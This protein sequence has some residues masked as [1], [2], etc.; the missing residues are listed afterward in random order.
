MAAR[1]LQMLI[2]GVGCGP[3]LRFLVEVPLLSPIHVGVLGA[4]GAVGAHLVRLLAGHPWFELTE[5]GASGD[6][7][8]ASLARRLRELGGGDVSEAAGDLE[9]RDL[10]DEWEAPLLLSALPSDVAG[11]LEAKLAVRGHLVVSNASAHRMGKDIPLVV[12]EVNPDHLALLD[13]LGEGAGGVVTNPNCVAA[14]LAVVL[15]PLHQALGLKSVIVTTFQAASGAGRGSPWSGRLMGNVLPYIP[16]E[17]EKIGPELRK[18]LGTLKDHT[19]EPAAFDVSVTSTRVPVEHGHLASVS[20]AFDNKAGSAEVI[21]ALREFQS[22]VLEDGLPLAP[23]APV[24]VFD[25]DDRPQPALDR[26]LGGGMTVSV[27]R[28]RP[29]EVLHVKLMVLSHNLVRGAAGAAL[30]NAELC[31]V[32]GRVPGVEAAAVRGAG[33][34]PEIGGDAASDAGDETP[35]GEAEAGAAEG[36]AGAVAEAV[37]DERHAEEMVVPAAFVDTTDDRAEE[38][39]DAPEMVSGFEPPGPWGQV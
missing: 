27:G 15:G 23:V 13:G 16:G 39:D 12:P 19:V 4:T 10:D 38:D 17:E 33:L 21:A 8:G 26:D 34:A 18:I 20:L 32:R 28:V 35:A 11:K 6:S 2:V 3:V 30:L 22:A 37:A 9:L 7:E 1:A 14:G 36:V 24:V 29:C 31:A 5:V 25:E